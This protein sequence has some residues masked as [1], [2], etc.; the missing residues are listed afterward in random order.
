MDGDTDERSDNLEEN[1][2]WRISASELT[3]PAITRRARCAF[4]GILVPRSMRHTVGDGSP[5]A[6]EPIHQFAVVVIPV[7]KVEDEQNNQRGHEYAHLTSLLPAAQV[8]QPPGRPA[9]VCR[10]SVCR[11]CHRRFYSGLVVGSSC[12]WPPSIGNGVAV[13]PRKGRP[14]CALRGVQTGSVAGSRGLSRQPLTVSSA[15][16][17]CGRESQVRSSLLALA[18]NEATSDDNSDSLQNAGMSLRSGASASLQP[19][20]RMRRSRSAWFSDATSKRND[21]SSVRNSAW[22]ATYPVSVCASTQGGKK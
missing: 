7:P 3:S 19:R 21:P 18:V 16:R 20:K 17:R 6:V 12:A 10:S 8:R 14:D 15:R 1:M 2:E 5:H 11:S 13:R 22:R 9:S 4:R